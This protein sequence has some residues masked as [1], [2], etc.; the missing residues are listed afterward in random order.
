MKTL[1]LLLFV[2]TINSYCS[3]C[4]EIEGS[5]QCQV[6]YNAN[7]GFYNRTYPNLKL[8]LDDIGSGGPV[9]IMESNDGHWTGIQEFQLDG[10]KRLVDTDEDEL[11]FNRHYCSSG[12]IILE[13]L[14]EFTFGNN[15]KARVV[16]SKN[17]KSISLRH[18]ISSLRKSDYT[19]TCKAF[20]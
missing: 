1:A 16:I 3:D 5:Y 6:T 14:K 13:V 10:V 4:P 15:E 7:P 9:F 20:L 2:L 19:V 8:R 12:K 11:E 18:Y 17:K